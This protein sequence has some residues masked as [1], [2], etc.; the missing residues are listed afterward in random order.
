MQSEYQFVMSKGIFFF[1]HLHMYA[2][3]QEIS[4]MSVQCTYQSM[5]CDLFCLAALAT[6][7]T[8]SHPQA[9]PCATCFFDGINSQPQLYYIEVPNWEFQ[10][11]NIV[12][13]H[14]TFQIISKPWKCTECTLI[15]SY[16]QYG[17]RTHMA[18]CD[19]SW[20]LHKLRPHIASHALVHT[21]IKIC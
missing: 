7:Q 11:L 18:T 9:Q 16:Y 8:K 17:F 12:L 15:A 2:Y 13:N 10:L 1:L 4:S 20:H 21:S 5:T 3:S 6:P 14:N 19:C